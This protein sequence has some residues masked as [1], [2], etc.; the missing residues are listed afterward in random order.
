MFLLAYP[1]DGEGSRLNL[2]D[3][4]VLRIREQVETKVPGEPYRLLDATGM[5]IRSVSV[6]FGE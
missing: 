6:S 1:T 2:T 4:V 3:L 5:V